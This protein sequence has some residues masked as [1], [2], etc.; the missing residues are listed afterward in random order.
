MSVSRL[1]EN[2]TVDLIHG[3]NSIL[4]VIM[5]NGLFCAQ[6]IG[7]GVLAKCIFFLCLFCFD[8]SIF[9][10]QHQKLRGPSEQ[11]RQIPKTMGQRSAEFFFFC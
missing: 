1:F 10:L 5:L 2:E 4:L 8:F 9:I 11:G 6:G 7:R 3:I